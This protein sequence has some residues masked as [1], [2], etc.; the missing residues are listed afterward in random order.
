MKFTS[1]LSSL[2]AL[3]LAGCITPYQTNFDCPL[4][5]GVPCTSMTKINYMIDQGILG[6]QDASTK[7]NNCNCNARVHSS[8]EDNKKIKIT[9]FPPKV[10]PILV[11]EMPVEYVSEETGAAV[12]KVETAEEIP[13][14][15]P[16]PFIKPAHASLNSPKISS[17]AKASLDLSNHVELI[18][19]QEELPE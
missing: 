2:C 4:P 19:P 3:A 15:E 7:E 1:N 18:P 11:L 9:H 16:T 17:E 14:L 13:T 6:K 8:E 5:K 12:D 10:E